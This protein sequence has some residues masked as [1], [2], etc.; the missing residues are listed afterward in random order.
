ME[1]LLDSQ[2]F[3]TTTPPAAS[4]SASQSPLDATTGTAAIG[5]TLERHNSARLDSNSN[6]A[7]NS[8]AAGVG[9]YSSPPSG[10]K[11]L[12]ID[13]DS[14]EHDRH[15]RGTPKRA[16]VSFEHP[17]AYSSAS[18]QHHQ[19]EDDDE[20]GEDDHERQ[21]HISP[22][23]GRFNR[24]S[25]SQESFGAEIGSTDHGG[26]VGGIA[27]GSSTSSSRLGDVSTSTLPSTPGS[28]D[29][30]GDNRSKHSSG[31]LLR[32]R[33]SS[34]ATSSSQGTTTT[35]STTTTTATSATSAR[36]EDDVDSVRNMRNVSGLGLGLGGLSGFSGLS[37]GGLSGIGGVSGIGGLSGLKSIGGDDET[38]K[39]YYTGA[40]GSLASGSAGV[41]N[42]IMRSVEKN[43]LNVSGRGGTPRKGAS[44]GITDGQEHEKGSLGMSRGSLK[45]FSGARTELG[46]RELRTNQEREGQADK[47]AELQQLSDRLMESGFPPLHPSIIFPPS[48]T[49]PI[50]VLQSSPI[51]SGAAVASSSF[52]RSPSSAH[53]QSPS[54]SDRQ[55]ESL[56]TTLTA[57]MNEYER[58]GVLVQTLVERCTEAEKKVDEGSLSQTN[59]VSAELSSTRAQLSDL[60]A[61]YSAL[62]RRAEEAER[63]A[64]RARD[65][66][67]EVVEREERERRRREERARELILGRL[68][69]GGTRNSVSG[70]T[71]DEV[72]DVY[73]RRIEEFREEIEE[74]R[75]ENRLLRTSASR[76][77]L[78]SSLHPP[79]TNA[80]NVSEINSHTV[81]TASSSSDAGI[82]SQE[83][84]KAKS[85]GRR[86][87]SRSRSRSRSGAQSRDFEEEVA[88]LEEQRRVRKVLEEEVETLRNQLND[89]I[90]ALEE[91]RA[92][93]ADA[94]ALAEEEKEENE[95][96]KLRLL[97]NR[98]VGDV[99]D[100]EEVG[101]GK[102][103]RLSTRDLI[104]RHKKAWRMK[105]VMV[106]GMSV[107]EIRDT[108][109][110]V[111]IKLRV[112]SVEQLTG[113]LEDLE[114]VL[115]LLPQMQQ[116]I[117]DVDHVLW[118]LKAGE[119][120][121]EVATIPLV[122]SSNK[123]GD[124]RKRGNGREKRGA[125]EE[126]DEAEQTRKYRPCPEKL[127]KTIDK[128]KD[129]EY[130]LGRMDGLMDFRRRVHDALGISTANPA[131]DV[132]CVEEIRKMVVQVQVLVDDVVNSAANAKNSNDKLANGEEG[133]SRNKEAEEAVAAMTKAINHFRHLFEVRS[134]GDVL[135]KMNE[136]YVF[137][138]EV[139]AGLARLR[140]A[141][142][143]PGTLQPGRVLVRAAEC[144]EELYDLK[145]FRGAAATST[146]LPNIPTNKFGNGTTLSGTIAPISAPTLATTS[147]PAHSFVSGLTTAGVTSSTPLAVS[148]M[149]RR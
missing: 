45:E 93:L 140:E 41:D 80:T 48:R 24:R 123:T 1:N 62:Q 40:S 111:C 107:K 57:L 109:Q 8:L 78:D 27:R 88:L 74:M 131:S 137:W 141:L 115:I 59:S 9:E 60:Q 79:P 96:L 7:G 42:G 103:S 148:Q 56:K 6:A 43:E 37:G 87:E 139:Q 86:R 114:K 127:A 66:L 90:H 20:E 82:G 142:G 63:E 132:I 130:E 147:A 145:T 36:R 29:G 26:S 47:L 21:H 76:D 39:R 10:E 64:K 92:D 18:S 31:G 126:E 102:E 138:A 14:A 94:Q 69:M 35:S 52:L 91:T 75:K 113:A 118:P 106:D 70:M 55:I 83:V 67:L 101:G 11:H 121:I 77:T 2:S 119:K 129:W 49:S 146:P 112:N 22:L 3:Y 149:E 68:G 99:E 32:Q 89:T 85:L 117:R 15:H 98:R 128:L 81:A 97:E 4:V 50:P 134:E 34:F 104:R 19:R 144:V 16:T 30:S 110:L 105:T 95:L 25:K 12:V 58:R 133:S 33:S 28:P 72:V 73:E 46:S 51:Q 108:L 23:A 44:F 135:P 116:F 38:P 124:G 54:L 143:V 53:G 100:G 13:D 120:T 61:Q 84:G 17:N 5:A 71:M 122:K 125:T 65:T 136:I